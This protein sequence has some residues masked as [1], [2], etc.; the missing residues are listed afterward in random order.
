M[1][2][3]DA[4]LV[5]NSPIPN[6][7]APNNRE[8]TSHEQFTR[9]MLSELTQ[10]DPLKPMSTSELS[11]QMLSLEQVKSFEGLTTQLENLSRTLMMGAGGLI[12]RT[13]TLQ[14]PTTQSE[15]S[16]TV[17]ALRSQSGKFQIRVNGQNYS[18]DL[19]REIR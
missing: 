12:G 5:R 9:V 10:Q 16:G 11:Q 2:L 13:V 6:Q 15:V 19:I 3:P 7:T 1:A 8:I 14:D 17:Q 18:G 4:V